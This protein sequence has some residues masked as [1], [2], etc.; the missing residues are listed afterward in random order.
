[1]TSTSATQEQETEFRSQPPSDDEREGDASWQ[2]E[3][4]GLAQPDEQEEESSSEQEEESSS[5]QEE[6][7]ETSEE[8]GDQ[9][10]EGSDKQEESEPRMELEEYLQRLKVKTLQLSMRTKKNDLAETPAVWGAVQLM[11]VVVTLAA[12]KYILVG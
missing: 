11:A 3:S 9:K 2:E 4:S 8:L 1:M 6:G 12:L 5:E 7:S 10:E